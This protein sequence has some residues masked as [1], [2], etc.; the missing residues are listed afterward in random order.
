M[1]CV[2]YHKTALRVR[3]RNEEEVKVENVRYAYLDFLETELPC[4][5]S[6]SVCRSEVAS[7]YCHHGGEGIVLDKNYMFLSRIRA[8]RFREKCNALKVFPLIVSLMT[9]ISR[10]SFDIYL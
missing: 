3:E 4:R 6:S 8:N 2:I 7:S 9:D 1:L 10:Y 5:M